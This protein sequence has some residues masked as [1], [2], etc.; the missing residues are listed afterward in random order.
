M[1]VCDRCKTVDRYRVVESYTFGVHQNGRPCDGTY[2]SF[3]IDLCTKCLNEVRNQYDV[4]NAHKRL[5]R[6][7]DA[8]AFSHGTTSPNL[9]AGATSTPPAAPAADDTPAAG[10]GVRR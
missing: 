10:E 2:L 1:N 9:A 3:K 7:D 4:L 6:E 5:C 8:P